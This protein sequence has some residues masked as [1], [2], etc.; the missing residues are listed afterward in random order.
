MRGTEGVL[1]PE[2]WRGRLP[3][4]D[5]LRREGPSGSPAPAPRRDGRR[6]LPWCDPGRPAG[7]DGFV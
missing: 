1:R 5:P 6:G 7:W 3:R 4:P 2:V